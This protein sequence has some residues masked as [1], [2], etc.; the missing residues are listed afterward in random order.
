MPSP[1]QYW[2]Q[3]SFKNE[4]NL[5]KKE[6]SMTYTSNVDCLFEFKKNIFDFFSKFIPKLINTSNVDCVFERKN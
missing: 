5:L 6:K 2:L 3:I 1:I 4:K